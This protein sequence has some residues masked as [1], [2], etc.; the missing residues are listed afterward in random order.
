MVKKYADIRHEHANNARGGEGVTVF[1]HI[2]EKDEMRTNCRMFTTISLDPGCSIGYHQHEREEDIYY[3]L[4]G[5]ATYVDNGVEHTLYPGDVTYTGHLD[6]HSIANNTDE[7]LEF[8]S[9]ILTYDP[10]ER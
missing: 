2:L 4:T 5:T 8:V 9:V 3:I 10:P 6:S 7:P 1:N